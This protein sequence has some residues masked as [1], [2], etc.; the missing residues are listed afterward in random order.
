MKKNGGEIRAKDIVDREGLGA[1]RV[2]SHGKRRCD[3]KSNESLR[4]FLQRW[5][6]SRVSLVLFFL[7]DFSN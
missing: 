6:S 2:K 5:S 3:V 7:P 1:R 4:Q